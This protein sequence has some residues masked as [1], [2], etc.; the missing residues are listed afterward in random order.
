MKKTKIFSTNQKIIN[1]IKYK[2]II[3]NARS[4]EISNKQKIEYCRD[5]NS[6]NENKHKC[7]RTNCNENNKL[8]C[9]KPNKIVDLSDPVQKDEPFISF[10]K[11]DNYL[12][13][14]GTILYFSTAQNL[15]N[16]PNGYIEYIVN[17]SIFC[18]ENK[19]IN[20]KCSIGSYNTSIITTTLNNINISGRVLIENLD[21][22][23][24]RLLFELSTPNISHIDDPTK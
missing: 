21:A 24:I 6:H 10:T 12:K 13:I 14:W 20:T 17:S 15:I 1:R 8:I 23:N 18:L 7:P 4:N 2:N 5:K 16:D 19:K 9:F 11:I 3:P 22:S